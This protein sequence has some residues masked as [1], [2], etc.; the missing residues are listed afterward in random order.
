MRVVYSPI[1]SL[2]IARSNPQK[3]VVFFAI[4]LKHRSRQRDGCLAGSKTRDHELF[5]P[6][7]PRSGAPGH[8]RD[9]GVAA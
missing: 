5:C 2:K 1:D 8:G 6:G 4:G 9:P 7:F 3:K